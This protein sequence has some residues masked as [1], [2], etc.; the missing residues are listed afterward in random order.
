MPDKPLRV[1]SLGWGV[2]SWTIAA[3]MA[4]G[5]L[6]MADFAVFADTK[7]EAAGTYAHMSGVRRKGRRKVLGQRPVSRPACEH[8]APATSRTLARRP[9]VLAGTP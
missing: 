6:P 3:M 2:Q 8:P 5:E 9:A 7:H 1:L 4:E